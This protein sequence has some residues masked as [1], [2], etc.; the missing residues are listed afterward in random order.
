M[1]ASYP[2]H[3]LWGGLALVSPGIWAVWPLGV[4]LVILVDLRDEWLRPL[5]D[6]VTSDASAGH[7][8]RKK[9][10]LREGSVLALDDRAGV[11]GGPVDVVDT[12]VVFGEN[13]ALMGNIDILNQLRSVDSRTLETSTPA[14]L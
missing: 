2:G 4:A 5:L 7:T 1:P 3:R 11:L 8:L 10:G 13:A 14:E 6:R 12:R 9:H